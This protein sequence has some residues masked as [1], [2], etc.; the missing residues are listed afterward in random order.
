MRRALFVAVVGAVSLTFIGHAQNGE[1]RAGRNTN[2]NPGIVNELI[3]D[4]FL[5]R[6]VET[7]HAVSVINNRMV[8]ALANDYRTVDFA[9]DS[10]FGEGLFAL[11]PGLSGLTQVPCRGT[12]R[13]LARTLSIHRRR[14]VVRQRARARVP[15]RHVAA[16]AVAALV[17]P[18]GGERRARLRP[19]PTG[20][21][22]APAFSS[23]A[24]GEASSAISA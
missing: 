4:P 23:T 12:T 17:R 6:Q 16:G 18:G 13:R 8:V 14:R 11:L 24:A 10:G 5:Q 19:M 7:K 3:G 21:S 15:H 22:M 1:I 20:I 9:L 2:M